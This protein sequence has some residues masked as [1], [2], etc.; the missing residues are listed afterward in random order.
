M[1]WGIC[2]APRGRMGQEGARP[3][4]AEGTEAGDTHLALGLDL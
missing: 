2:W 4:G 3:R 1:N